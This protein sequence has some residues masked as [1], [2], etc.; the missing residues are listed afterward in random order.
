MSMQGAA[1][2]SKLKWAALLAL[3]TI[4]FVI[5]YGI[6]VRVIRGVAAILTS[7]GAQISLETILNTHWL[8][9]AFVA[10]FL[11]GL[12][13]ITGIEAAFARIGARRSLIEQPS[14][15]VCLVF[16]AWFAFGVLRWIMTTMLQQQSVLPGNSTRWL[17]GFADT[18]FWQIV[19]QAGG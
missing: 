19:H 4:I 3:H 18:F 10:G 7:S 12:I 15:F 16:A 8:W 17:V 5:G 6:A 11:V 14:L 9:T 13:G 2:P 1:R